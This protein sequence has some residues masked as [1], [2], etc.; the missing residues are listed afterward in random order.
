MIISNTKRG[1]IRV[2]ASE[3]LTGLEGRLVKLTNASGV[4][5]AA[6]PAAVSDY[7][8]FLLVE[9]GAEGEPV[10][11]SPLEPGAQ[12]RV[13]LNGTCDPAAVLVLA[14]PGTSADKGKVRTLPTAGGT[15]RGLLIAEEAGV[16]E[17][18]VLAR[19]AMLGN[20]TVT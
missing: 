9:G 8:L 17:Q 18:L 6:L 5:K 2:L 7:A 15:Y 1:P 11:L 16:D 10:A 19:P 13:R 14:D 3:D 20:L 4:L 12:V